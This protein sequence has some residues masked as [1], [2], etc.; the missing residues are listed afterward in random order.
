MTAPEKFFAECLDDDEKQTLAHE[1]RVAAKRQEIISEC[2]DS[3]KQADFE[4]GGRNLEVKWFEVI[5]R[6]SF[7]LKANGNK[8]PSLSQLQAIGALVW[9][10]VNAQI[11]H[12]AEF[13]A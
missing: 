9:G 6:V 4:M 7:E 3:I 1:K 13:T 8:E 11:D 5:N 10:A 2:A 12:V